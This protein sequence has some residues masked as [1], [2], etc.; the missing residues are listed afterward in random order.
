MTP[1]EPIAALLGRLPRLEPGHVWLAGAGPGDPGCL[2]LE[3][4]S[5]LA[6]AEIVVHDALVPE[7]I[8][9]LAGERAVRLFAGKRGG[10]PSAAQADITA[11]LIALAREGRRVLRLKGGDPYVFGRGGEEALALRQASVPFRVLPGITSGLGGLTAA[12]IP[13]TMRGVNQAVILA[14]GHGAEDVHGLDWAALART[15]QPIVLYMAMNNL[16]FIAA[17][18]QDGGLAPGTPAAIV[19]SAT[20]PQQRV[21]VSSLGR[22]VEDAHTAGLE[23]PALV[24]IGAIVAMRERLLGMVE[25]V[26]GSAP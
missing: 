2:T 25:A 11:R 19:R 9:S 1:H 3:V 10:K 6:Q 18:L 23:S 22:V 4:A 5:G 14:T 26:C 21:L 20:T 12:G 13:A 17:A 8:L 7:E 16:A 24:V 15:N